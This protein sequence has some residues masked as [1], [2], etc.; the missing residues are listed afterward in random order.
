MPT[1]FATTVT[2]SAAIPPDPLMPSNDVKSADP[3]ARDPGRRLRGKFASVL[4]DRRWLLL[5]MFGFVF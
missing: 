4:P 5:T 1:G 2:V 3:A